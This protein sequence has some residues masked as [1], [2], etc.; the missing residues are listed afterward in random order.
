MGKG[1]VELVQ[2][3]MLLD[4]EW[5]SRRRLHSLLTM[6]NI[7]VSTPLFIFFGETSHVSL[8]K[9]FLLTNYSITGTA[10]KNI[11]GQLYPAVS[12][13][14]STEKSRVQVNFNKSTFQ[15]KAEEEAEAEAEAE[16]EPGKAIKTKD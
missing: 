7:L 15:Y 9:L 1:M 6:V 5:I 4:A 11:V 12:L 3:L 14:Y 13:S 8:L 16:A 2:N 10:F